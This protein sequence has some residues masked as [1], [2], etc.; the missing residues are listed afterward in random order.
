MVVC[1][2][3]TKSKRY[4][5]EVALPL[6]L[7][8]SGVVLADQVKSMDWESRAWSFAARAPEETVNDVRAKIGALLRID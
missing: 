1:P 6:G 3:T 2:I 7:G 5:F 8:V 4:V